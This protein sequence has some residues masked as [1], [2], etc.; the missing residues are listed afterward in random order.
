[1]FNYTKEPHSDTKPTIYL[2]FF[3][4]TG[5]LSKD[6]K[7]GLPISTSD[8]KKDANLVNKSD[9]KNSL[10]SNPTLTQS[11]IIFIR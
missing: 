10:D 8:T 6:N 4:L 1:M 11:R 7:S 9:Q 5:G 3:K 2:F